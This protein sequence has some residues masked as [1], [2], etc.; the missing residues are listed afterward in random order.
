MPSGSGLCYL[1]TLN[2]VVVSSA[3]CRLHVLDGRSLALLRSFGGKGGAQGLLEL[4]VDGG[5]VCATATG[6]VVVA[7]TK[8]N[9]LQEFD[10]ERGVSLSVIAAGVVLGPRAVAYTAS[11]VGVETLAVSEEAVGKHRITL[12]SRTRAS[13]A[14]AVTATIG[15]V[16]GAG[17]GS[18]DGPRGLRFIH[19]HGV[20][21]LV[22][23]DS[24]NHRLCEFQLDGARPG[25]AAAAAFVRAVGS[26]SC[27]LLGPVDVD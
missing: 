10:V 7:D 12:L 4:G 13:A 27:G 20:D 19:R 21:G 9:R 14:F 15:G 17:P 25:H 1:P 5:G 18:F 22:V 2:A 23:A 6:T 8:N 24:V 26:R 16:R 11:S 3:D